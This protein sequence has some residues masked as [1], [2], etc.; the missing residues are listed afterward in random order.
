MKDYVLGI[1][2]AA[3][4]VSVIFA[5][6]GEGPGKGTRKLIGGIFLA[7]AVFRPMGS[8][9]LPEFS[10]EQYRI[11]AD[12]AVA[13]GAVQAENARAEFITEACR[14]YILSKAAE[15]GLEPEVQVSLDADGMPCAVTLT[16]AASPSERETLSGCIARELGLG[17]EDVKWIDPYQSSE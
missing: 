6:G 7:L 14:A 10:L 4:L 5:I 2:C 9:E 16:A 1:L 13:A 3:F 15:V 8:M 17:K 11:D 12:S